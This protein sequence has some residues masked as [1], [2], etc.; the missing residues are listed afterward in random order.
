VNDCELLRLDMSID[1]LLNLT[2]E[3]ALQWFYKKH[4][5][6]RY[7]H[8][9]VILDTFLEQKLGGD[10][11]NNYAGHMAM[12]DGYNGIIFFGARAIESY[13]PNPGQLK[14]APGGHSGGDHRDLDL[15]FLDLIDMREDRKC[16]NVVIYYGHNVV[17]R[18][19]A[20][21]NRQNVLENKL[22]GTSY[23]E[24]DSVFA[25]DPAK[26]AAVDLSYERL[27]ERTKG[28]K[29]MSKPSISFDD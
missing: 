26:P 28:I 17:R 23:A 8:W 1:N 3:E 25:D 4:F 11:H 9:A 29:W 5:T 21:H 7:V 10:G 13:W 16:I 12:M 19:H 20:I 24:I 22:F 15:A 27:R 14:F 6:D 18:T 2:D